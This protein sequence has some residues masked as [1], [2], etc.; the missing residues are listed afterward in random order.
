M[1]YLSAD[2]LNIGDKVGILIPIKYTYN[3]SYKYQRVIEATVTKITPK[4]TKFVIGENE[5]RDCEISSH[6]VVL[7]DDAKFSDTMARKYKRCMDLKYLLENTKD[8]YGCNV[9]RIAKMDDEDIDK[10]L[11][12]LEYLYK[13]YIVPSQTDK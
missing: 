1:K 10:V 3:K 9:F 5:F 6:I 7:D 13:K 8:S 12:L 4:R 2:E 11:K